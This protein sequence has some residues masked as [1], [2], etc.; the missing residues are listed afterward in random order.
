M[1]ARR[2]KYAWIARLEELSL[3]GARSSESHK[4]TPNQPSHYTF[5]QFKRRNYLKEHVDLDG[6]IIIIQHPSDLVRKL[7]I[8]MSML[9]FNEKPQPQAPPKRARV[10]QAP[11][12]TRG[13]SMPQVPLVVPKKIVWS[14]ALMHDLLQSSHIYSVLILLFRQC[15][16]DEQ[17]SE[18]V[19]CESSPLPRCL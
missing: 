1:C 19:S 5:S 15:Q 17:G 8:D 18:L 4:K 11:F 12:R 3:V 16:C 10:E 7:L 9:D 14:M 13:G 6:V 2:L